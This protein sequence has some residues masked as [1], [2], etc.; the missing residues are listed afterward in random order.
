MHTAKIKVA[1][2]K[3]IRSLYAAKKATRH[4]LAERFGLTHS[5]VCMIIKRRRWK[6]VA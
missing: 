4:Q 5:A 2:V 6:S 1:D 3:E